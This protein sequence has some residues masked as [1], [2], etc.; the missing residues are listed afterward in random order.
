M[1]HLINKCQLT[2]CI[3][4]FSL[5]LS[6]QAQDQAPVKVGAG[7]VGEVFSN[8]SGGI[9]RGQSYLGLIDFS[10]GFNTSD[11]GL[12]NNGEF[13]IQAENTHGGSPSADYIGDIQVASNIDN[14]DYTY[15]YEMWVKQ[16][17]GNFS[18]QLGV[19]DLNADYLNTNAGGHF[20]N[21]SFGIQPSASMNMPVPIF[22]MNAL[23]V[24]LQ[25]QITDAISIQTGIWDGDPGDL[26]REAY[27]VQWKLS[28]EEGFLS[29]SEFHFKHSKKEDNYL[30]LVKFGMMYHSTEFQSISDTNA[31]SKGNLEFHIIADQTI[32]NKADG[33]K[34]KLD[35]FAQ[36]GYLPNQNI[37][38][39]P[40]SMGLGLNYTG[41]FFDD[42]SDVLGLAFGNIGISEHAVNTIPGTKSNELVIE[43]SYIFP[44]LNN[45]SIQPDLQYIINPGAQVSN[46]N[47]FVGLVRTYIDL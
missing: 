6:L 1:I 43:L 36:I 3:L 29:V 28:A 26:N 46:S 4:F 20:L 40:F 7:Y 5:G 37:N 35:V 13:Y 27:N 34:G 10:L 47:A 32:I 14:G 33:V 45:I 30:G 17:F 42:A 39:I 44:L 23:G 16:Q 9:E 25:Y 8:F 22:P 24:S 15:L 19:I 41:V 31:I 11:L 38:V 12:W 18:M 2:L 21:S